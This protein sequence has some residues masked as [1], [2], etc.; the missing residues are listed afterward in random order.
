MIT[1]VDSVGFR[2]LTLDFPREIIYDRWVLSQRKAPIF[3]YKEDIF[4]GNETDQR[5]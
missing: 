3:L 2:Q 4:H 5:R 1:D